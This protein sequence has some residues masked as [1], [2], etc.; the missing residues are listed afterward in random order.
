MKRE[1]FGILLRA[2]SPIAHAEGTI[3]N[4]TL[5]MRRKV[6]TRDGSIVSVP[7]VTGDT[8]RHALREAGA[9]ALLDGLGMVES[10]QLTESACRLLMNGG[11]LT[12]KGAGGGVKL[13]EYRALK[14]LLPTLALFGGCANA[15][16][17]PG[18]LEVADALL[19]CDET[20]HL[21]PAWA[22][23]EA[24]ETHTSSAY[25]DEETRVR[26]DP[27]RDPSKVRLLD[28]GSRD[29][30]ERRSEARERAHDTGDDAAALASKSTMMPRS[31]E[32]V[33]PGALFYWEATV[34][35]YDA[36]EEDTW[37]VCLASF[38]ARPVVGGKRGTGHGVLEPV[39]GERARLAR[40][41]EASER[42]DLSSLTARTGDVFRAHVRDQATAIKTALASVAA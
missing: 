29:A 37:A 23:E 19:V 22:L 4:A 31:C 11:M 25:L 20:A 24:G 6:R 17:V 21:L 1:T 3:G 39:R 35:T 42:V 16:L 12:G 26:F 13:S 36:L 30:I 34:T 40:L 32:V 8:M 2:K 18:Q 14:S 41:A 27:T 5:A 15:Q 33:V 28:A 10:P 7:I 9:M 38:L